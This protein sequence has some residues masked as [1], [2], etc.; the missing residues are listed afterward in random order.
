MKY[1][2]ILS[3][4]KAAYLDEYLRIDCEGLTKIDAKLKLDSADIYSIQRLLELS[5]QTYNLK[6]EEIN[7]FFSK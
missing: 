1:M 4:N 2:N 6:K 7:N 3:N 5:A